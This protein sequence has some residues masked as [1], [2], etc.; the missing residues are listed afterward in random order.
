VKEQEMGRAC[1]THG[2]EDE[3]IQ[4]FDEKPRSK[5]DQLENLD[6]TLIL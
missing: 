6:R 4:G 3:C 5:R 2:R 1:S